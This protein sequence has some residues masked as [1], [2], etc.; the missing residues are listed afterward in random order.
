MI[1]K[2]DIVLADPPWPYYGDPNKMAAAGKHYDLMTLDDICKMPVHSI[3]NNRAAL[4]L[5]ATGPRLPDAIQTLQTW[6]FNYRG[7]AF[8]WVKTR[9]DGGIIHGQ[10]VP[11]TF[12]KP[13]TE[14]ILT[15]TMEPEVVIAGTTNKH[16]RPWP[17]QDFAVPQVVLT[18]RSKHSEK[19][20]IFRHYIEKLSGDRP[21][22]ELFGRSHHDGWVTTGLEL[23]GT[24]YRTG[25]LLKG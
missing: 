4:F 21:R 25:Q 13:T 24:D 14:F 20:E 11:P 19:P 2:F 15:G 3:C 1:L 18:P 8:V 16:G 23:T 9:M 6:G 22:I 12:T 17:L 10:G 7:V 5:W